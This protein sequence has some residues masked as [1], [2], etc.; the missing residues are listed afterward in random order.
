VKFTELGQL[1]KRI[2]VSLLVSD[3]GERRLD[4]AVYKSQWQSLQTV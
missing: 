1:V 2:A 4:V 3:P